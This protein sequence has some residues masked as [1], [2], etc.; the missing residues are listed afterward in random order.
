[1]PVP[2]ELAAIRRAARK[3]R[4]LAR[5]VRAAEARADKQMKTQE[6]ICRR[7]ACGQS[8]LSVCNEDKRMPSYSTALNWLRDYPDFADAH[9]QAQRARADVLFEDAITIADDAR[10]DWMA[11]NDPNNPGWIANGENIQRSR[12]RVDTRKWAAGKLN[13]ARYGDK[14]AVEGNPD[15]PIV[16]SVTH[17]IVKVVRVETEQL[18][19]EPAENRRTKD[20]WD[21]PD[22]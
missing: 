2:P 6:E 7:I 14:L 12:L 10:N 11:R 19:V 17:E 1:M 18:V 5:R 21:D 20:G 22:P 15:T 4:T 16:V 3:E 9:K 13:A 8:L